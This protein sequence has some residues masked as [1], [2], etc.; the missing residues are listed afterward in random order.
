VFNIDI[1][2]RRAGRGAVRI[3]TC[4]EDPAATKK[5]LGHLDKKSTSAEASRLAPYSVPPRVG[6][7][8]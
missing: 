7:F 8:D 6:M 3:I 2:T 4:I 5:F 1:E